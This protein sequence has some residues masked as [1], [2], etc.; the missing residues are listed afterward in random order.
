MASIN[1]TNPEQL[2]YDNSLIKL[3]VL[4]GIK[5]EGLDR[6]RATLKAELPESPQPPIRHNLDL[7]NDTLRSGK[8]KGQNIESKNLDSPSLSEWMGGFLFFSFFLLENIF[9]PK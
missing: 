8:V 9:T 3:T 7:Y 4:G 2:I 1:T 6:M 5:I